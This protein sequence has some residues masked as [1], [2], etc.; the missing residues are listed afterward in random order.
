MNVDEAL[1]HPFLI[2]VRMPEK[3]V[4]ASHSIAGVGYLTVGEGKKLIWNV[5]QSAPVRFDEPKK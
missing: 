1:R 2:E 4:I 3:E 5:I